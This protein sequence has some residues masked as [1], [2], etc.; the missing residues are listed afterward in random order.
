[1]RIARWRTGVEIEKISNS[2]GSITCIRFEGMIS[3]LSLGTP[4]TPKRKDSGN[5]RNKELFS[6]YFAFVA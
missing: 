4:L 5:L 6:F 3:A 1:M 2:Y